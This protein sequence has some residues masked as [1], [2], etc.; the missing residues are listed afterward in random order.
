MTLSCIYFIYFYILLLFYCLILFDI[1]AF[2][3]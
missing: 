3:Q 1:L 2:I